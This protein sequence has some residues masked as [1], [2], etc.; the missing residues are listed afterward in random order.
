MYSLKDIITVED[1]FA[2]DIMQILKTA[3]KFENKGIPLKALQGK[4]LG[5]LFF[6]E[7]T[8][9]RFSFEAAMQRLGGSVVGFSSIDGTSMATKGESVQD[10]IRVIDGYADCLV[11][12]HPDPGSA[13]MAADLAQKPVI[14]GGDGSN[15]HP[16]QTLVDLY[17]IFQSQGRLEKLTVALVGDLKHGRVPHSLAK[18]LAHF[19]S[20]TQLWV[21]PEK[22]RMP[23]EVR[24][25]VAQNGGTAHEVETIEEVI[26]RIDILM[27]TRVQAERF[28]SKKEYDSLKDVYVL[29][30]DMFEN[31]RTNLRILHALPRRYEIPEEIDVLPFAY[32]FQQAHGGMY[33]RAALL[34][35]IMQ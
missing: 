6:E 7:S 16:T 3:Q 29:R 32:Y 13:K 34:Q 17:A 21:A 30:S 26:P 8:R 35:S 2:G 1:L 33:V 5:S 25:Y 24:T 19:P 4:V 27:M 11:M 10:T 22:L 12:R 20:V 9:T 23:E 31:A 28:K 15:E 18:A 14:N